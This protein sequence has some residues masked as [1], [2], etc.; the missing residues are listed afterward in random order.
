M[1][2]RYNYPLKIFEISVDQGVNWTIPPLKASIITE[3]WPTNGG[4]GGSVAAH[5]IDEF[6]RSDGLLGPNWL[7][8]YSELPGSLVI[9]NQEVRGNT[10]GQPNTSFWSGQVF[11]P[12]QY[13]QVIIKNAGARCGLSLR[14]G[15]TAVPSLYSVTIGPAGGSIA[16]HLGGI[17]TEILAF[18]ATGLAAGQ[19]L[20]FEIVGSTL[21]VFQ[22]GIF[23]ASVLDS[24]IGA[25][26]PGLYI[27]P[28]GADTPAIDSWE[29][30]DL[31]SGPAGE[32]GLTGPQGPQ[33]IQGPAGPTGGVGPQGPKGDTGLTGPPGSQGPQGV[34]G[35][36]GPKGDPGTI[37]P[38]GPQGDQGIQGVQGPIGPQGP[39]GLKGDKG[40]KGDQ[41]IQGIQGPAGPS[42]VPA[43]STTQVQ[44]NDGGVFAGDAGLT[45][46]KTTDVLTV[47]GGLGTTPLNATQLTSGALPDA[48]LSVNVL[49]FTGGYPG[50]TTT[51]LRADGTFQT[52]PGGTPPNDS[53]TN[54]ILANMAQAT[55]KGRAVG[56]G[57]GDPTDLT[58][59]QA[60]AILNTFAV[61][62][63]GLAPATVSGDATKYLKGDGT[64][65]V[66][67]SGGTP[68]GADTQ[69]QFNDGGVFGGSSALWFDKAIGQLAVTKLVTGAN[70]DV[71]GALA[72][73][74][75]ASAASLTSNSFIYATSFIQAAGSIYEKSRG[76]P[77]G[78]AYA[79]S[80][81]WTAQGL[82][83]NNGTTYGEITRVGNMVFFTAVAVWGSVTTFSQPYIDLQLPIAWAAA[84]QAQLNAEAILHAPDGFH[85][86]TT[87]ILS[88]D[89]LRLK[90]RDKPMQDVNNNVPYAPGLGPGTRLFVKGWYLEGGY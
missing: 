20:R 85:S 14:A 52:T 80:P 63:K 5:A 25:G 69:V 67:V 8:Q 10:P 13:S 65:A 7:R 44:F 79:W 38:Q 12:D 16:K 54:A 29:G 35:P 66:P 42:G 53:V 73:T 43:G 50:G 30:G 36:Q 27:V 84:A 48:R 71:G 77:V 58:A 55:I 70:A 9:S 41:G 34:I 86:L 62:L 15:G 90:T 46:N 60:T 75:A 17:E 37:G 87:I 1:W 31:I 39:Q 49:K 88:G 6:D 81:N 23:I 45:Y 28:Q 21:R 26:Q 64:W 51:F 61:G 22:A 78:H 19:L 18:G 3:G 40:D 33:G 83:I 2:W 56:A 82:L 74:G 47:V 4:G 68:G 89:T 24:S 76:T 72:V 59:A 32:T 11:A 57:T